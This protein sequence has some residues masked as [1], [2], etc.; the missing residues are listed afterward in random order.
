MKT[1]CHVRLLVPGLTILAAALFPGWM[2]GQAAEIFVG[3][4]YI[5]P[6]TFTVTGLTGNNAGP[7][8]WGAPVTMGAVVEPGG[9]ETRMVGAH[10]Q[11][12]AL[13]GD[14]STSAREV[15]AI[16]QRGRNGNTELMIAATTGDEPAVV[17]LLKKPSVSVNS[18]NQFGSTA[19]MGAAAGGFTNIIDQLIRRGAQV[20]AKSRKG[21]T[22]LMFAARNGHTDVVRRLIAAGAAVDAADEQGQT[23]LMYAAGGGH[24]ASVAALATAGANVN[25]RSRNGASPLQLASSAQNQDLIVLLTRCGAKN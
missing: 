6:T 14:F 11:A 12:E 23:A 3:T 1:R 22:A 19:L 18:A 20:N 17:Q 10:L 7:G 21:S 25:V 8:G 9:F 5:Y 15:A 2:T 13:V 4:E 16:E 24:V